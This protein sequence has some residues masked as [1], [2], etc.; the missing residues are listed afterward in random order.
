MNNYYNRPTELFARSFE[1]YFFEKELL[2]AKA[3]NVFYS[4]ENFINEK[5]FFNL[6]KFIKI[7]NL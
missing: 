2:K 6:E 3:P 7:I 4:Y 1:A 5:V